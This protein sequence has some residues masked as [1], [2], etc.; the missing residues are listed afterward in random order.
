MPGGAIAKFAF[1]ALRG[2]HT[3]SRHVTVR[4]TTSVVIRSAIP[5]AA[6]V[7]GEYLGPLPVRFTMTDVTLNIVVPDDFPGGPA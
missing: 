1:D 6:Q 3:E 7:D 4:E 2:R 5:S